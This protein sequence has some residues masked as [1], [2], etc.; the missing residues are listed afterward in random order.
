MTSKSPFVAEV[1]GRETVNEYWGYVV[2]TKRVD[3]LI[4]DSRFSL[5]IATSR[6]GNT[7]ASQ[8]FQLREAVGKAGSIQ[9]VFGSPE[10]GL[11]DIIG[12]KL[13]QRFHFTINLFAEQH[14][15]T[16]RTEEA[17]FAALNLLNNLAL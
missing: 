12:H 8:I 1:I 10:R 2:E 6:Y 9:V 13:T 4:E 3:E 16:V 11:F 14:V 7:L 15:Q 17:L 5:K